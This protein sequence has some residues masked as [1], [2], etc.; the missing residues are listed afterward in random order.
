[1]EDDNER[2]RTL[3]EAR[4]GQKSTLMQTRAETLGYM[5]TR[6]D[7]C[8]Y[9]RMYGAHTTRWSGGDGAN[10]QNF[11]RG[12]DIR[13]AILPP[14]NYLLVKPDLAQIEARCL[15]FL[16]GQEDAIE[17][18]RQGR[19]PYLKLAS[20]AYGFEVTKEM[21]K[22]RGTGKQLRLSCNYMAGAATIQKTAAHG[23]YGPPVHIDLDTALRW[24]DVFREQ[25]PAICAKGGY[26]SSA[27]RMIAR[28]AGGESLEWGPMRIEA[29]RIILPNG[30]PL[31]YNNL[32]Y[33]KDPETGEGNWRS[34]TRHGWA[35]LYS[36]KLVEQ[37]TQALARVIISQAAIRIAR[38]GYR[39]VNTEH[40]SLWILI[41]DDDRQ[42]V[43]HEFIVAEMTREPSW[44]P[45]IP[46][47]AEI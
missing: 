37:T 18:F 33:Y 47:A 24:R 42:Q 32:E 12:S 21:P 17:D 36:G 2:V 19:D 9:L 13:K 25:N 23:T 1:M 15:V 28:I 31:L 20:A 8:V 45:G 40:D 38:A 39:I 41:P 10:W 29:G 16:A 22:E 35:K 44:L 43:H 26:W 7:M 5:S 27:G 3:A 4:L 14:P 34:Q 30:C 46:L 6:G 11:K